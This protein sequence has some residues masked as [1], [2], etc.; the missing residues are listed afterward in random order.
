MKVGQGTYSTRE[1]FEF[2]KQQGRRTS[3]SE[4]KEVQ[5]RV[6]SDGGSPEG[7][8]GLRPEGKSIGGRSLMGS[9]QSHKR[10]SYETGKGSVRVVSLSNVTLII[11][12]SRS[13]RP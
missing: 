1:R 7:P 3:V 8:G 11:Q 13:S 10:W 6:C 2:L 12:C 5:S 4:E 9:L